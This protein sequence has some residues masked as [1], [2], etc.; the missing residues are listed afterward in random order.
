MALRY[1]LTYLNSHLQG[2]QDAMKIPLSFIF[3]IIFA[4]STL[5]VC[6]GMLAISMLESLM[7]IYNLSKAVAAF[8]TAFMLLLQLIIAFY[9]CRFVYMKHKNSSEGVIKKIISSFLAGW[10]GK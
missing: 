10:E 7:D 2:G 3:I 5:T 9:Y 4:L 1:L 8:I 6:Q